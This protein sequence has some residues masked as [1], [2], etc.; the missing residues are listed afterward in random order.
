MKKLSDAFHPFLA[1]ILIVGIRA[2]YCGLFGNGTTPNLEHSFYH[3]TPPMNDNRLP[4]IKDAWRFGSP[5]T[6]SVSPV[7]SGTPSR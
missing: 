3:Y 4:S 2:G 5:A 6:E 7:N 1:I